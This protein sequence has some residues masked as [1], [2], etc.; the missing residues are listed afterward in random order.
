MSKPASLAHERGADE[1]G[2]DA[3]H[4][5]AGHFARRWRCGRDQAMAEGAMIS[6]L[7]LGERLIGEILLPRQRASSL[8]GRRARAAAR[9]LAFGVRVHVSRRCASRRRRAPASYMPAQP[10]VM[11][12]RRE[13]SVISVKMSPAPPHGAGAVDGR[14]GSRSA[15]PSLAEYMHIGETTTRLAMLMSRSCSGANI[16]GGGLSATAPVARANQVSTP[17]RQSLCRAGAD[18]RG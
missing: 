13:T 18:S 7:P 1:I 10:G 9:I 5:G 16:G 11:R 6:Q 2:F 14:D 17:A 15:S 3:I 12:P 8:C 4:V